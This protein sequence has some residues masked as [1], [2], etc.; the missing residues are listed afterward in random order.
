MINLWAIRLGI[1]LFYRINKIGRDKRFDEIRID[2][3]KFSGF[4]L[5]QAVS[6][7]V[8]LLN[9]LLLFSKDL[10][11]LSFNYLSIVGVLVWLV[12]LLI[13]SVSDCQ[14]FNF[15]NQNKNT[16]TNIGLWKYSRH[17]NYFGEML[18]WIGIFV[19]SIF[20]LNLM[21]VLL[22]LI[23]PLLIILLLRFVTGIPTTEKRLDDKFKNNKE[24]KKYKQ[25]T[26][27]L[28]PIKLK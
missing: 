15:K 10:S 25:K 28:L 13:E 3:F 21:F 2:F 27:L 23:S 8:I 26:N 11:V 7:F 14:K 16:W 18:C 12:G 1:Y 5:L 19:F 24:Y 6:V 9:C 4:W 20:Y 17:P 22:S